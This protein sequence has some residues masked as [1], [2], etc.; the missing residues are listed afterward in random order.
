[1]N[2]QVEHALRRRAERATARGAE[3]VLD[4]ARRDRDVVPLTTKEP[5]RS[6]ARRLPLAAAV[7]VLLVGIAAA[8]A[9][10]WR[11][12]DAPVEVTSGADAFCEALDRDLRSEPFEHGPEGFR[13]DLRVYLEPGISDTGR[14]AVLDQLSSHPR[15][16]A[17]HHVDESD[18]A[19]EH[20]ALV[21]EH[22]DQLSPVPAGELPTSYLVELDDPAAVDEVVASLLDA[23]GVLETVPAVRLRPVDLVAF[24][25]RLGADDVAEESTP[26]VTLGLTEP[27][28][29]ARALQRARDHAPTGSVAAA[30][31]TLIEATDERRGPGLRRIEVVEAASTVLAVADERC[32]LEADP[33][34]APGP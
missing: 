23:P 5:D 17:T 32:A 33:F 34:L 28:G 21:E 8:V 10:V 2:E 22:P 6:G 20:R 9:V 31:E 11:T 26:R 7:V 19:D 30:I 16:R 25:G 4:A 15:V 27:A 18:T 14:Q 3:A 24:V 12:D 29:L 13:V 1:M